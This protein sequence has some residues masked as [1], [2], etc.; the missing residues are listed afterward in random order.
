ML[1]KESESGEVVC[2]ILLRTLLSTNQTLYPPCHSQLRDQCLT[3]KPSAILA[4]SQNGHYL[5]IMFT[6]TMS[7][8]FVQRM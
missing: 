1:I 3:R 2:V 6:L 8:A 4:R 5:F 7:E